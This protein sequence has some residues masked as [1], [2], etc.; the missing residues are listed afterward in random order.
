MV[1]VFPVPFDLVQTVVDSTSDEVFCRALALGGGFTDTEWGGCRL[2]E[3]FACD[4]GF[5]DGGLGGAVDGCVDSLERFDVLASNGDAA[6]LIDGGVDG[7][8]REVGGRLAWLDGDG[9]ARR[10]GTATEESPYI[11]VIGGSAGLLTILAAFVGRCFFAADLVPT[12][13]GLH[14]SDEYVG[15]LGLVGERKT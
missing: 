13:G 11:T 10:P 9:L 6:V 5:D 3:W 12:Y 8:V 2:G 1:L 14:C 4:L 7:A 15:G